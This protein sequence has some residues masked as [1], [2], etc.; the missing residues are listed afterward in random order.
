MSA[1]AG[2]RDPFVGLVLDGKY[3][4]VSLLARGGMGRVYRAFHAEL[5]REVAV[6][7]MH[8]ELCATRAKGADFARRFFLEAAACAKLNHPNTVVV[9]DYGQAAEDVFYIAMEL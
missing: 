6:K 3:E 4:V 1:S 9:Y 7:L 5:E 2:R 8:P